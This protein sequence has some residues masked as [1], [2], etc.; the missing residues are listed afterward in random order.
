VMK[1]L[2]RYLKGDYNWQK[3]AAEIDSKLYRSKI[4]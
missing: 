4:G 3:A 1:Q 2:A